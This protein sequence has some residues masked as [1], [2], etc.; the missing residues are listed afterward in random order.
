MNH[1]YKI[2]LDEIENYKEIDKQ[3]VL[4][5]VENFPEQCEESLE[6][7]KKISLKSFKPSNII[8]FG[9]G[10]SGIGGEVLSALVSN[11]IKIPLLY[12]HHYDPPAF[13]DENTL[14]FMISY[15]G[16][17]EEVLKAYDKVKEKGANIIGITSGGQLLS[18]IKEDSFDFIK[19]PG[20]YQPR[21]ALGFLFF[22]MLYS[23]YKLDL[24]RNPEEAIENT[25][26]LMKKKRETFNRNVPISSNPAKELAMK[27]FNKI[28]I[29]YSS[30]FYLEPVA[31]RWKCQI[32]ENAKALSYNDSFPELCHNTIC[33]WDKNSDSQNYTVLMLKT[34]DDDKSIKTR[35]SYLKEII[36]EKGNT[37]EEL[38][39][40]GENKLEEIFTTI[41][42]GDFVS[43]YLGLLRGVN[44]IDI[45]RINT[46]KGR[47]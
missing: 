6:I 42:L 20:G 39:T 43:V 46:L 37:V 3:D 2:N 16:N 44:P 18:K 25:I 12:Y 4:K 27:M 9:M 45:E 47:L 41:Y 30:Q 17:T 29:I 35:V 24:C 11:C 38:I 19:V 33:G 7:C 13:T 5:V 31:K 10:G 8:V 23:L 1:T 34:K 14:A 21:A 15:S 26:Q 32:N 40:V 36:M 22:P 28:P